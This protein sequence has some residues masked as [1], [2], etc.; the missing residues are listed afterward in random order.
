MERAWKL[1]GRKDH[2]NKEYNFTSAHIISGEIL[3]TWSEPD[4]QMAHSTASQQEGLSPDTASWRDAKTEGEQELD[5][6]QL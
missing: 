4:A 6:G 2:F 5:A 1:A 3:N